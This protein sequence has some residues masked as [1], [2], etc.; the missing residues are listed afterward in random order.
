MKISKTEENY[1]KAIFSI[2]EKG[3]PENS[4]ISISDGYV[5]GDPR[6]YRVAPGTYQARLSY[7][8][9]MRLHIIM[10]AYAIIYCPG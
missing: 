10:V 7:K 8:D 3:H 1:L 4:N 5:Y 2:L 9:V 6:G